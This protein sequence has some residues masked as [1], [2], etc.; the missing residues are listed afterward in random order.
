M[1]GASSSPKILDDCITTS[2]RRS[3][4]FW[5][6]RSMCSPPACRRTARIRS[7]LRLFAPVCANTASLM[8][9]KGRQTIPASLSAR[10]LGALPHTNRPHPNDVDP[11][12]PRGTPRRS[13]SSPLDG[14]FANTD[15][16]L[17]I[18]KLGKGDHRRYILPVRSSLNNCSFI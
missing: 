17:H 8:R 9:P 4:I 11:M 13:Q 7:R 3:P 5:N 12:R 10:R 18:P 6:A 1:K 16:I 2:S 15:A 14:V